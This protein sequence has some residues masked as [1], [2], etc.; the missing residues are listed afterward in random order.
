M[1]NK[2][3]RMIESLISSKTRIK[4]LMKFFLNP[5]VTAY[6]RGL[7][8]EFGESTNAV[9]VELNRLCAANFLQDATREGSRK[10]SY[11]AN[12]SHPLFPE[13]QRIVR[14]VSGIEQL[15]GVVE[16]LG[17]VRLALVTGDYA[18]GVDSGIIDLTIV[19][20]DVDKQYL[21]S[22]LGKAE[23]LIDRK[24]RALVLSPVE[25]TRLS[26]TLKPE[27]SLFVWGEKD[28]FSMETVKDAEGMKD[29]G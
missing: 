11:R 24:V 28:N 29:A 25:Y 7:A 19:G 18:H 16:R 21:S 3:T 15:V 17:S 13:L 22:L 20:D 5:D 6:L 23:E 9:R 12:R 10:K 27:E 4:L 26:G 1:S 2:I 8:G 14:K